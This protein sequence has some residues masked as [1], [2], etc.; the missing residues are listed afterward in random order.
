MSDSSTSI[1]LKDNLILITITYN[2]S[3]DALLQYGEVIKSVRDNC[4]STNIYIEINNVKEEH[5]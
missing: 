3:H 4:G 5:G 2:N 1:T